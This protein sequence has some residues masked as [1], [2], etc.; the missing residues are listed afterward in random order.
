MA[1]LKVIKLDSEQIVFNGDTYVKAQH[2]ILLGDIVEAHDDDTDV[3]KGAFYQVVSVDRFDDFK[4]I[5][6]EN[7]CRNRDINN[8]QYTPYRRVVSVPSLSLTKPEGPMEIV[9]SS[10]VRLI[11]TNVIG[12]ELKREAVTVE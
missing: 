9:I 1:K 7:D 11:L 4:F 3:T 6:D 2:P 8:D 5:D 10:P 12:I